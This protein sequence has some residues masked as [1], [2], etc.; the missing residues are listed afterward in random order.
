ML[1]PAIRSL[2]PRYLVQTPY[3]YIL[4]RL[5]WLSPGIQF[6]PLQFRSKIAPTRPLGHTS[7]WPKNPALEEILSTQLLT[8]K[9]MRPYFPEG[10]LYWERILGFPK[11]I[12]LLSCFAD[13]RRRR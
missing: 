12:L 10:K 9:E 6:L 11:S 7:G 1:L 13:C 8:A 2:A 4:M 3:R 5:H